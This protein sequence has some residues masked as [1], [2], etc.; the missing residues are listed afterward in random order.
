MSHFAFRL[1]ERNPRHDRVAVFHGQDAEHLA[2]AGTLVLDAGGWDELEQVVR[3]IQPWDTTTA[4][5]SREA[6]VLMGD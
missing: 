6:V 5:D 1:K 4:V 3:G 2:L